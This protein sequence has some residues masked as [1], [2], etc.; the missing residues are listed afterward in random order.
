MAGLQPAERVARADAHGG[1]SGDERLMEKW[2]DPVA[3]GRISTREQT[4]T[5]DS[6]SADDVAFVFTE[7]PEDF[8]SESDLLVSA[9]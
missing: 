6:G 1:C 9:G 4:Q 5:F 8:G 3:Q 2:L 7:L